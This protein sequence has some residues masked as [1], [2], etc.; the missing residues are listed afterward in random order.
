MQSI[1]AEHIGEQVP[2]HLVNR[3]ENDS[4]TLIAQPVKADVAKLEGLKANIA[5]G[6]QLPNEERSL[7]A[8]DLKQGSY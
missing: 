6:S 4:S 5:H 3:I 8:S 7:D 2:K 1:S